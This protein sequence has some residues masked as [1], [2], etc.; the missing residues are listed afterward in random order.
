VGAVSHRN[1]PVRTSD[2]VDENETT[3]VVNQIRMEDNLPVCCSDVNAST[4]PHSPPSLGIETSR[5]PTLEYLLPSCTRTWGRD[6]DKCV[7]SGCFWT[8]LI[9]C[10]RPGFIF[11]ETSA[12]S[13][14]WPFAGTQEHYKRIVVAFAGIQFHLAMAARHPC[15]SS[16]PKGLENWH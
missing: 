7:R 14:S 13:I 10:A 4:F 6:W 9:F 1:L 8:F 3:G 2:D 11:A 16:A 15:P 5:S 12:P